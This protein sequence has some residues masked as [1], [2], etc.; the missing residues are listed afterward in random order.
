[1]TLED[2]LIRRI[3]R[4]GPIS[5]AEFMGTALLHPLYGYYIRRLPVGRS[6]DFITA[7]EI[8]QIFGEMIAAWLIDFWKR[9]DSP[10]PFVLAELGPGNGTLMADIVRTARSI[11]PGFASAAD[12]WFVEV[13]PALRSRQAAAVPSARFA[14]TVASVPD[15]FALIIANEF[16]DALPVHQYVWTGA[17]WSERGI[18]WNTGTKRFEFSVTDS[19]H[20]APNWLGDPPPGEREQGRI[21][22]VC[23]AGHAMVDDLARRTLVNGGGVLIAD[24]GRDAREDAGTLQAVRGHRKVDPLSDPGQ[25]D[26]STRVDFSELAVTARARGAAVHGPCTQAAFLEMIG[27]RE[28]A[29]RLIAMH[30]SQRHDIEGALRRLTR[31]EDMGTR[32]RVMA[33]TAPNGPAPAG[34]PC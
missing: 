5:V 6:G 4:E 10:S 33:I 25:A 27:I 2:V 20:L 17:S 18:T 12:V 24:Y 29:S 7:P 22:E 34:F 16:F 3:R 30:P 31:P 23:P 1:M 21:V 8:H 28:R 26:L 9:A 32:F 13:S 15:S 19:R 14:D 11:A